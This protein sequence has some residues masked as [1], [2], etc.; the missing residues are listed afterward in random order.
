LHTFQEFPSSCLAEDEEERVSPR[1]GNP[2]DGRIEQ[3]DVVCVQETQMQMGKF[4][5][6]TAERLRSFTGNSNWARSA[7]GGRKSSVQ[8]PAFADS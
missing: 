2:Q 5:S 3:A 1:C 7:G 8:V 6:L 4:I